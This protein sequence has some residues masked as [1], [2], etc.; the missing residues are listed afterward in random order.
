MPRTLGLDECAAMLR[1]N[2]STALELAQRGEIPGA[3][4]GR[5]WVFVEEDVLT[6]LREQ[7]ETQVEQRKKAAA[8][9]EIV[10]RDRGSKRKPLPPLPKID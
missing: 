5:A 10:P 6:Y 7:I 9:F 1:I 4:I 2:P 8:P 3:K